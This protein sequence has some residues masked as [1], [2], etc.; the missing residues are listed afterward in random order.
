M[1]G[2]WAGE[3]SHKQDFSDKIDLLGLFGYIMQLPSGDHSEYI[4]ALGFIMNDCPTR[5][6]VDYEANW[7]MPDKEKHKEMAAE[8]R[9]GEDKSIAIVILAIIIVILSICALYCCLKN[10][11]QMCNA[12]DRDSVNVDQE[13][14][15]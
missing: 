10:R 3:V 4:Y 2:G 13:M 7:V 14:S 8:R 9:R 5:D 15:I 12:K 6:S 1:S 11:G